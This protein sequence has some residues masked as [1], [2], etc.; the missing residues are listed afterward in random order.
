M[1]VDVTA[2][3][4]EGAW[5]FPGSRTFSTWARDRPWCA[6]GGL[7]VLR[8]ADGE[9]NELLFASISRALHGVHGDGR[10]LD[11]RLLACGRDN[12]GPLQAILRSL[13]LD[14]TLGFFPARD[15]IRMKLL[16]RHAVFVLYE[17][18]CLQVKEW[19]RFVQQ[20]EA[21]RKAIDPVGLCVIVLDAG[22]TLQA[23][24]ICDFTSGQLMHQVLELAD[25]VSESN[26]WQAYLHQRACW[27]AG[28]SLR[29]A[30]MLSERLL[31]AIPFADE[32]V[33]TMLQDY[34]MEVMAQTGN[35]DLLDR[36]LKGALDSTSVI[37]ELKAQHLL[38]RPPRAHGLCIVPWAARALLAGGCLDH[39]IWALRHSLVCAPLASEILSACMHAEAQIRTELHCK[40]MSDP[41]KEETQR[42]Y[43]AFVDGKSE[44]T[45]YPLGHPSR[46]VLEKDVWAFSSLGETLHLATRINPD[47][48]K[49][50]QRI[51]D[52]RNTVA[53]GHYVCWAH[54]KQAAKATRRFG[55][56]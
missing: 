40:G 4:H 56:R 32:Q 19:D 22:S 37:D 29:H 15:A 43:E 21:C 18:E 12:G 39:H 14:P 49:A 23:Q 24:P 52:L 53:H 28:G 51:K 16:D 31:R 1:L 7:C 30:G 26:M 35:F 5:H 44:T 17:Q 13:E 2:C 10:Q 33:E 34:A 54:V 3:G 46:P 45:I 8:T 36:Y 48:F 47:S 38:W 55:N 20:M 42:F 6:E 9:S 11:L 25:G 27:D 50:Y 41:P